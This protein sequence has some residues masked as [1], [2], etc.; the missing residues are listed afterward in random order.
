M[1]YLLVGI[2]VLGYS[3][4]GTLIVYYSRRIDA[5]SL[6]VYRNVSLIFVML[7]L[8]FFSSPGDFSAIL[9]QLHWVAMAGLSGTIGL[10][11][12]FRSYIH[13]PVGISSGMRQSAGVLSSLLLAYF[14]F[15]EEF[16]GI[17]L[18]MISVLLLGSFILG[19]AKNPMPHLT[20]S[21]IRG[22]I[23]TVAS[24]A[25][26]AFSTFIMSKLARE[27]GPAIAGY[28]LEASIGVFSLTLLLTRRKL[29][30]E[31]SEPVPIT[32]FFKVALVS[33]PTLLGTGA[34]AWAVTIG[35]FGLLRAY[36][37]SGLLLTVIFSHM[38]YKEHLSREQW[39]GIVILIVG[40]FGL[41]IC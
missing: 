15:S 9:S 31:K 10:A 27:T 21:A 20:L 26:I 6:A 16:R 36:S 28:L 35:S 3:L 25:F 23:F 7:P 11:L 32:T 12:M 30:N 41:R 19:K 24:G 4:Q 1:F 40:I 29:L 2:S 13:L 38:L 33:S 5:L 17:Q 14:A 34:A 18:I 8:L 39:L 37:V 22:L